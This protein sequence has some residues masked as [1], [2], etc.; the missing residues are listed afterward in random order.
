MIKGNNIKKHNPFHYSIKLSKL[1]FDEAFI[2]RS[3]LYEQGY[4][5]DDFDYD[6]T[7]Y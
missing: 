1:T 4:E 3:F 6:T 5:E 2:I 7:D